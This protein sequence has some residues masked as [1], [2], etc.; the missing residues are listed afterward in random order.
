MAFRLLLS[1]SSGTSGWYGS[2]W[3]AS[4]RFSRWQRPAGLA[5]SLYLAHI[6]R[7]ILGVW[8]LYCVISLLILR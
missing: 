7:D 2:G 5:F 3:R 4:A 8:C 6:E 1:G